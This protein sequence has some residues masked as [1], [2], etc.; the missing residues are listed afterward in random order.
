M[1]TW[2]AASSD[3]LWHAGLTAVPL[4]AVVTALTWWLPCRPATK[5]ALWLAVL[6]WLVVGPFVPEAPLPQGKPTADEAWDQ[7][8]VEAAPAVTEVEAETGLPPVDGQA[9]RGEEPADGHGRMQ[10]QEFV[11][12]L[13]PA[14]LDDSPAGPPDRIDESPARSGRKYSDTS[15]AP[16]STGRSG[17]REGMQEEVTAA[18]PPGEPRSGSV[19]SPSHVRSTSRRDVEVARIALMKE[20]IDRSLTAAAQ[21]QN[22]H[23][24]RDTHGE[25]NVS[26]VAPVAPV[27]VSTRD[28]LAQWLATFI[29]VRD[30]VRSLPSVPVRLWAA[31]AALVML[32]G[33]ARVWRFRR[34]VLRSVAAPEELR[35]MVSEAAQCLGLR[36][37][38]ETAMV[39]S[40]VSPM[41]WCGRRL[42]L[43]FPVDL[44]EQ[45]DTVAR[46]AVI[47][48]ELAH[49]RRRDHWVSWLET[50]VGI[51]YWWHPLAWWVRGQL[52]AEAELCCDLWVTTLLPRGR[53]AYA[54]ALLRSKQYV[55]GRPHWIPARALSMTAGSP[56]GGRTPFELVAVLRAGGSRGQAHQRRF[57]RRLMMVMTHSDKPRLSAWGVVLVLMVASIGWLATPARSCP[58]KEK[59]VS[60]SAASGLA[61]V[62]AKTGHDHDK[63]RDG[64]PC[65]HCVAVGVAGPCRAQCHD[66]KDCPCREEC[67]DSRDCSCAGCGKHQEARACDG[68]KAC[69]SDKHCEK[70]RTVMRVGPHGL[71]S[72]EKYLAKREAAQAGPVGFSGA[73]RPLVAMAL[74]EAKGDRP[75][76]DEQPNEELE[77]RLSRLEDHLEHLSRRLAELAESLKRGPGRMGPGFHEPRAP[78]EP[79]E[80]RAPREPRPPRP[81]RAPRGFGER[82]PFAPGPEGDGEIVRTYKLPEGKLKALTEL[83]VRDDVPVLVQPVEGG[84]EVHGT[85][86]QHRIFAAFVRLIDPTNDGRSMA[87]PESDEAFAFD[88]DFGD[89]PEAPDVDQVMRA[90]QE[91]MA[92]ARLDAAAQMEAGMRDQRDQMAALEAER[93]GLTGEADRL[94]DEAQGLRDQAKDVESRADDLTKRA[95]ELQREAE[96]IREEANAL[97]ERSESDEGGEE[98]VGELR[99]RS[100]AMEQEA[101]AVE[102]QS[103]QT[104]RES[105]Q[106]EREAEELD[107]Q[108]ERVERQ[109]ERI[110]SRAQ[111]V[112][113][114]RE[115][116]EDQLRELEEQVEE[117]KDK[118]HDREL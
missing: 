13:R 58:P 114:R 53:R 23:V 34:D 69:K 115:Q 90:Y 101:R 112:E 118:A 17:R 108:A 91:A 9:F 40:R 41:V 88:F 100:R 36:R 92:A 30:A 72:F 97:R 68:C 103:R 107:R 18:L 96:R 63:C 99:D 44:W 94:R 70:C 12:A 59:R 35:S 45:L 105:E 102:L 98:D 27:A 74:G 83:M 81:P 52:R 106:V 77:E 71:R 38:P 47:Y 15:V 62:I 7:F 111:R 16:R 93:E 61:K 79:R 37:I 11:T 14:S 73:L 33:A 64:K 42:R 76:Y 78:R 65:G 86:R 25:S 3:L 21:D 10:A 85:R 5:H 32:I 116:L 95:D 20:E 48:H 109:A 24:V 29:T 26:V 22:D 1:E 28:V 46:R 8:A 113:E 87:S 31:G 54:E 50:L 80:P 55:R 66:D 110:D 49:I 117:A 4:A 6:S 57:G 43:I 89:A 67:G 84:I 82:A 56:W 39:R 60:A 75:G 19:P 51:V 104:E 2:S